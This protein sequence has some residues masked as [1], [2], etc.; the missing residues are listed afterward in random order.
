MSQPAPLK[1]KQIPVEELHNAPWNANRVP[2][3]V[4]AKVRRSIADF[5]V[6]ENLVARARPDGGYEVISGNHRL[7]IYREMGVTKAPVHVVDVD[8][9]HARILAQTLNRTRGQDDAEAYAALLTDV[10]AEMDI[11][12]VLAYLPESEESIARA[13]DLVMQTDDGDDAD[14]PAAFELPENPESKPGEVYELGPHR[15]MCG[16]CRD[17]KHVAALLGATKINVAFTSPPYA[18]RRKYDESSGFAP[19]IPDNY[20]E[21]FRPVAEN[22]ATHL[23]ADGSWFVNIK[24]GVTPS[25]LETELYVIDLVIAHA[26]EWGWH[27]ATEYC[28]ERVGVPKSVTRRFKN[29]FEPVYQF[30]RGDWKMRPDAVRHESDNVPIAAG[31]GAG[32]TGWDNA[33]GHA[34]GALAKMKQ[35]HAKKRKSNLVGT[36]SDNQGINH[37]EDRTIAP[38]RAYPGNRLPPLMS[39]HE[40]T[41]HTAAFP[42]GLPEFFIKAYS[43][44]DDTV[45]DPFMGSGST[46]IAA[47]RTGRTAY[48]MEISPAYC[49]VI[50]QR[51]ERHANG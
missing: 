46:L 5:G 25:G 11:E 39:T 19:I 12:Q 7:G 49:D 3:D 2:E 9:A 23:A 14:D 13:M 43:D 33:Q 44:Q 17:P 27:F 22:V 1:V 28:W 41:G 37:T 50:R 16:N 8:D 35:A 4:L 6:V 30:T 29:Q 47:H 51:Y 31:P 36:A 26:R 34:G 42:V 32:N 24:P 45:F 48:G 38:G 18:D 20:V 21:W 40:A 15:L 10:L